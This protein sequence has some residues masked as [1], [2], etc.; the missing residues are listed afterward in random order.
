MILGAGR[1]T[2][3]SH[4]DPS[5]GIMIDRKVTEQ[6]EPGCTIARIYTDNMGAVNPAIELIEKAFTYEENSPAEEEV[7]LSYID[8]N[9][10]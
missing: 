6:V 10:L 8:K 7:V 5:A 3:L 1:E 4:I 2:R 9:N